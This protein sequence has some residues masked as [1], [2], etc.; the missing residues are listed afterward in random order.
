MRFGSFLWGFHIL[1]ICISYFGPP[2]PLPPPPS[3][4]YF[5]KTE[6]YF[7]L[8][9]IFV[10]FQYRKYDF[11]VYFILCVRIIF[12]PDCCYC[13]CYET[14]RMCICGKKDC[15]HSIHSTQIHTIA[16]K[17]HH[18]QTEFYCARTLDTNECTKI[19]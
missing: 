17:L 9:G 13:C 12:H 14:K 10:P 15:I 7:N 1:Y 18:R 6:L 4:L 19:H 11:I 2:P 5:R 3:K 16:T 8:A